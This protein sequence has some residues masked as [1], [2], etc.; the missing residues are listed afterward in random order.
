M[1]Y[2]LIATTV[3]IAT[4]FL[5]FNGPNYKVVNSKFGDENTFVHKSHGYELKIPKLY[6]QPD[7]TCPLITRN[8]ELSTYFRDINDN[9]TFLVI[10]EIEERLSKYMIPLLDQLEK[11]LIDENEF[12]ESQRNTGVAQ[13]KMSNGI[14]VFSSTT[15]AKDKKTTMVMFKTDDETL[16]GFLMSYS[17]DKTQEVSYILD[18]VRPLI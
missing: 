12:F 4:F 18:S 11:G 16:V 9:N 8:L 2:I 3:V 6:H 5:F 17:S 10:G 7:D 15:E 1:K 14:A 13:I